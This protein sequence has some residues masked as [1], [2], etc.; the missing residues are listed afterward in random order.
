MLRALVEAAVV[1]TSVETVRRTKTAAGTIIST[2]STIT[3]T[4]SYTVSLTAL[5]CLD[6]QLMPVSREAMVEFTRHLESDE[7]DR[8]FPRLRQLRLK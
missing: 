6:I 5:Q 8:L 3:S 4:S 7:E 2:I 1:T